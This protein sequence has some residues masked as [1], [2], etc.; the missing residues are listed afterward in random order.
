MLK[1]AIGLRLPT[2]SFFYTR[3]VLYKHIALTKCSDGFRQTD[4]SETF[5]VSL[6][7]SNSERTNYN[8]AYKHRQ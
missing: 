4:G 6:I 8:G 1:P 5:T 3:F 2:G 7:I